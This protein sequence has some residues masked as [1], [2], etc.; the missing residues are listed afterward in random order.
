LARFSLRRISVSLSTIPIFSFISASACVCAC[1]YFSAV[2]ALCG[3]SHATRSC[4]HGSSWSPIAATYRHRIRARLSGDVGSRRT[5]RRL[6]VR[7][8]HAAYNT[9]F[10]TCNDWI[11]FD[12]QHA[13]RNTQH[14]GLSTHL[15]G[16]L[17]QVDILVALVLDDLVQR[18]ELFEPHL[19]RQPL[20]RVH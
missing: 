5:R 1:E 17:N 10:P 9:G 7:M 15:R 16:R 4:W 11:R 14:G 3:S 6:V 2:A 18:R 12:I 20:G 13:T 8:Q 19:R